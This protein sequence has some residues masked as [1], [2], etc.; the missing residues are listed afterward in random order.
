MAY[1]FVSGQRVV[2]PYVGYCPAG[3][4]FGGFLPNVFT[5]DISDGGL[6][7]NGVALPNTP[8]EVA[9]VA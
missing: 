1:E 8:V 3:E 5:T 2:A 4:A 9:P 7:V 6:E